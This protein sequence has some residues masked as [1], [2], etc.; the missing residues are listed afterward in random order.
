MKIMNVSTIH[1]LLFTPKIHKYLF[2]IADLIGVVK[3]KMD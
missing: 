1:V 2:K 3:E